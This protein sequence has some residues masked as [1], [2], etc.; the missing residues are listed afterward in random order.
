MH[1]NIDRVLAVSHVRS[2]GVL[3]VGGVGVVVVLATSDLTFQ[4]TDVSDANRR[5]LLDRCSL[6][7]RITSENT[8]RC[9]EVNWTS[10]TGFVI[11]AAE[12]KV[13]IFYR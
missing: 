9:V 6:H 11:M 10:C 12:G 4:V 1:R 8:L 13:I 7:R 3:N 5:R 2:G